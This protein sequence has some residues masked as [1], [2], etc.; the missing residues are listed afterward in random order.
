[1]NLGSAGSHCWGQK[2][3]ISSDLLHVFR[4]PPRSPWTN[5][6]SIRGSKG[7]C[8]NVR[9]RGPR[10]SSLDSLPRRMILRPAKRRSRKVEDLRDDS[11]GRNCKHSLSQYLIDHSEVEV[12]SCAIHAHRR[13]HLEFLEWQA[14]LVERLTRRT[15]RSSK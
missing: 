8:S 15:A 14:G 5:M 1:L 13:R 2:C 10:N 6:K 4:E 12:P 9:P 3:P 11:S 7:A